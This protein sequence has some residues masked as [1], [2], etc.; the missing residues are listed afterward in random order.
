MNKKPPG[1]IV[2]MLLSSGV[3]VLLGA[4][5]RIRVCITFSGI[6]YY[7]WERF[8]K[9]RNLAAIRNICCL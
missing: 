6:N 4:F 9:R 1:G 5:S 7:V 2:L 8:I 3:M